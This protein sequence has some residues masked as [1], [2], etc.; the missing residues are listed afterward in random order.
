[1]ARYSRHRTEA[2]RRIVPLPEVVV[3]AL[4]AHLTRFPAGAHGFVFAND[5]G[6]P[7][8][9]TRFSDMWRPLVRRAGLPEGVGFHQLRHFYASLLI[10]HEESVKTVQLRLGHASAVETLNTYSHLWPDSDDR[11]REAVDLVLG[12]DSQAVERADG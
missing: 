6:N 1:V 11:T 10:R 4:A 2:S 7:I 12:S 3:D 8:R 9:R 5:D